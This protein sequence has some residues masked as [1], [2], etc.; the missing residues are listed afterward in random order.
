MFFVSPAK[1]RKAGV[2]GMNGRNVQLI[3]RNNRR[4]LY[5]LV[6]NKVK[7]KEIL[8]KAGI[9]APKLLGVVHHQG[10]IRELEDFLQKHQA[11]VIKPA[12]G[13][14]GKG[15]LVVS[16]HT[17]GEYTKASGET[18][19]LRSLQRH[20]SNILSGLYSLG[21]ANDVAM[22]EEMVHFSDT[23]DGFSFQGVPDIRIIVYKGFPVMAMTRLSTKASD[24]KANLHQGAVGVGLDLQ[25]GQALRAVQFDRPV[26]HHPDTGVALQT[27]EVPLWSDF[28]LLASRCYEITSLGYL[29]VDIV[30]DKLK[31]PM[32]LELNARPG[33][34]IQIANGSGL[35]PRVDAIDAMQ[36]LVIS[37]L[38]AH[39]R[40]EHSMEHLSKV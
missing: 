30:L 11:F 29:G 8:A 21:G 19:G 24:G 34:A 23:F 37:N 33:L 22:I 26:S 2:V 14:G 35:Q 5:P 6:D 1:L 40:A 13:S 27:F 18:I 25:T 31:G 28:L 7:T 16:S 3:A 15:I 32:V 20:S 17:D 39:E 4:S 9:S 36:S 10:N 12:K 38:S